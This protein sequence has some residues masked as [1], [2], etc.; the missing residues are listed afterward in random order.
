MDFFPICSV[1]EMKTKDI[2]LVY[3]AQMLSINKK[4]WLYKLVYILKH[5]KQTGKII[6]K[7]KKKV[8]GLTLHDFKT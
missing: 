3:Q 1:G 7:K 2:N 4:M 8:E 6:L 5:H